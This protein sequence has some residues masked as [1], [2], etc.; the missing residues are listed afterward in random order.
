[1]IILPPLGGERGLTQPLPLYLL[2][3]ACE[4]LGAL[5]FM[6]VLPVWQPLLWFALVAATGTWGF[7]KV[8]QPGFKL[9]PPEQRRA[10]YR[11]YVWQ[12]AAAVGSAAWLLYVPGNHS[13]HALLGMYL[14]S[15]AGL[16]AMWGVRDVPRTALAVGLTLGP[17]AL[18]LMTEGVLDQRPMV[19]LFGACGVIL[20]AIIVYTSAL[21]AR[22]VAREL[23]LRE[24]AERAADAVAE[25]SLAKSR[26]FAAISHDLRQPVHAIGLYLEPLAQMLAR[27]PEDLDAHRA[28]S[29]IRQSWQAL[30]GLLSQVLDLTRMDAGTLRANLAPV[31]LAPVVRA[32]VMQHSA[33]AERAGVRV[34]AL[35]QGRR[36][37]IAMTD[38]LML[39]RVLSNLLDNA[40]KFSPPG[41]CV[42]IAVRAGAGTWRIQVRDSG[43]GIP[44]DQQDSVFEEFV[45]IDNH[46]RNRQQGYGLGLAISRRFARAM[47]GELTLDSAPG[48]GS[49]FT[50]ALPR[51]HT[52]L[53]PAAAD[54]DGPP[55]ELPQEAFPALA[56][57]DILLV[58]DDPLVSD[59]MCQLL[60]G[61]GLHVRHAETAADGWRQRAFGEVAICDV[62][63]PDG[64]SGLDLALRLRTLGR[65]VLLLSGETDT[66]LR[67]RA[68]ASGLPLLIKPVSSAD[69]RAALAAIRLTDAT[70]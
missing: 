63:L 11:R 15:A 10:R 6:L 69:L 46:A 24:Q 7:L 47:L 18:R 58:E 3:R 55:S 12:Q 40:I 61:W 21:Y 5:L 62:R 67:T 4:L 30:D 14:A 31:E 34:V 28:V 43:P 49:C 23:L 16:V 65:Q 44:A 1:M 2:T 41:G 54:D 25:T 45:Q 48:R 66:A 56:A 39:R 60:E 42:L 53:M 19:F 13:M 9:L 57:R 50:L 64:E 38:E 17:T 68:A 51:T 22:H 70:V 26:F 29:G 36:P 52:A 8:R 35:T 37:R 33:M 32:V 20:I 27:V 59:A